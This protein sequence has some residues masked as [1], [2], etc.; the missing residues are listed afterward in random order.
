MFIVL[1]FKIKNN[2]RILHLISLFKLKHYLNHVR[3][4]N[5]NLKFKIK[6]IVRN[7]IT[8]HRDEKKSIFFLFT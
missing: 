6:C 8:N 1:I 3:I 7:S 2:Y 5:T 4:I